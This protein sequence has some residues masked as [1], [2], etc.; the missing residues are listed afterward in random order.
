MLA[1]GRNIP[2]Y[3]ANVAFGFNKLQTVSLELSGALEAVR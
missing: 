2:E 1:M 3:K